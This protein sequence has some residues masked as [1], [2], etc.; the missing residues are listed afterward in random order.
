MQYSGPSLT[1]G[2]GL[3]KGEGRFRTHK[4]R[5]RGKAVRLKNINM[6]L[7]NSGLKGRQM[8]PSLTANMLLFVI[9]ISL[10]S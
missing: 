5:K 4:D 3:K 2:I 8:K 10:T 6:E 7:R 9:P 1:G